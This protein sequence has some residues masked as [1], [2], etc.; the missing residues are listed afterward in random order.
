MMDAVI[1]GCVVLSIRHPQDL[2]FNSSRQGYPFG[3]VGSFGFLGFRAMDEVLIHPILRSLLA[4]PP[5]I[6]SG[7]LLLILQD[8]Y[9]F[10]HPNASGVNREY[11]ATSP[12]IIL[13]SFFVPVVM[14]MI[15]SLLAMK[16]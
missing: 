9:F 8:S 5:N 15:N 4:L 16:A 14:L 3:Q 1:A 2:P 13:S 6:F 7:S 10:F 11:L 12:F